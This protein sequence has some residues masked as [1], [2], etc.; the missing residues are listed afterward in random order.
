MCMTVLMMLVMIVLSPV[1]HST[2]L[3][4]P[5]CLV[6]APIAIPKNNA[7]TMHGTIALSAIEMCIRDSFITSN[8]LWHSLKFEKDVT[9]HQDI[10]RQI[11]DICQLAQEPPCLL[12]TSP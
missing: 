8:E 11:Q 6:Y 12:Y 3:R 9:W 4:L 7:K 10:I 2:I 5:L 1:T